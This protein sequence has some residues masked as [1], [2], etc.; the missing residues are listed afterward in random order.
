[1][2]CTALHCTVPPY[3]ECTAQDCARPCQ[4]ASSFSVLQSSLMRQRSGAISVEERHDAPCLMD[5][6]GRPLGLLVSALVFWYLMHW[7]S[8]ISYWFVLVFWHLMHW[9]SGL[10]KGSAYALFFWYHPASSCRILLDGLLR[11]SGLG[12]RVQGS[13]FRV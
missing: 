8:G 7:S 12:F 11:V 9:S 3:H 5:C 1:M 10:L 13:G 6:I 4:L 2:Y